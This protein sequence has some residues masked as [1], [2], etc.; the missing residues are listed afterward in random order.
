MDKDGKDGRMILNMIFFVRKRPKTHFYLHSWKYRVRT[1]VDYI[2]PKPHKL[3]RGLR[4]CKLWWLRMRYNNREIISMTASLVF[5][6]PI[7]ANQF[8]IDNCAAYRISRSCQDLN[9]RAIFTKNWLKVMLFDD[10]S[11]ISIWKLAILIHSF[12]FL[13]RKWQF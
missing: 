1:L 5:T 12:Q 9:F 13:H 4:F 3:S 8:H 11:S 10:T 7:R 6:F 2:W